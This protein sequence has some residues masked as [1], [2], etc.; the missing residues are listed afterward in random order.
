[1]YKKYNKYKD[2]IYKSYKYI[3][4]IKNI[5]FIRGIVGG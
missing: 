3:N 2:N 1:M 4:L 5:H